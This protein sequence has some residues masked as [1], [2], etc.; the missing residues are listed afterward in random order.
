MSNLRYFDLYRGL[1]G[2]PYATITSGAMV[3][4]KLAKGLLKPQYAG[5]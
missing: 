5:S 4:L 3:P 1:Y 2:F